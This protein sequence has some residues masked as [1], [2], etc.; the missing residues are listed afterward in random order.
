MEVPLSY[1]EYGHASLAHLKASSTV[2]LVHYGAADTTRRCLDSLAIQEG[3][4]QSV[5]IADHGPGLPLGDHLQDHPSFHNFRILRRENLGFGAGCNA[6]AE[7]AFS[8]GAQWVWF[9]NNDAVLDAPVLTQLLEIAQQYPLVDL[10]GTTQKDGDRNIGADKLPRWFPTPSFST[11]NMV[12]LPKGCRQLG[13][14]ETLSGASVLVSRAAWE[15]MGPWP[16][17]C[18]LYWEDVA[19]CLKAHEAGIPMVMTDLEIIHSR[20]TTTGHHSPMTTYYGVRNGLLLHS[21]LWPE[22]EWQRWRQAAHL[23]QKRLIQG[24]WHMLRP[25]FL[26]ILDARK[27]LRFKAR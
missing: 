27:G 10:W 6:A 5:I 21:D 23:M 16:E 26:G 24:N 3:A 7:A 11:Q 9:L 4:S 18:F 1:Q 2:I 17:W 12:G 19:W 25:T 14:R 13:A 8:A 15:R 20:N 22:K